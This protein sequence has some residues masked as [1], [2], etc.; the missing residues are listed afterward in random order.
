MAHLTESDRVK[1]ELYLSQGISFQRIGE[2]LNKSRSTILREVL[3]HRQTSNKVPHGRIAN[4][5]IHRRD[6]DRHR[7]CP[8][9]HCHRQCSACSHCN[10]MCPRFQE[11]I[12]PKLSRPRY[13]CNGCTQESQCTL[14]KSFYISNA[15]EQEYR[16]VLVEVRRGINLTEAQCAELSTRIHAGT[17]NGQSIHH[18]MAT[19]KDAFTVCEKT[20][21]GYVNAGIIRTKRGDMPRSCLMKP[22]KRKHME[23]KVDTKCRIGRSYDDFKLYNQEHPD[24]ALVEM[25]SVLGNIG[26][27]VLLTLQLNNCGLMLAFLRNSNNS[28][29]VIDIFNQLEELL[30][31]ELFQRLFPVIL[32]D[33]GSEFSNPSALE[34]SPFT[35]ELRTRIFYCNPYSSWQKGHVENNH[36]NLRKIFE[37]GTSFDSQTQDNINLA[38]SHINSFARRSLNDVPAI[39]LFETLYGEALPA[40]LGIRLIPSDQ[41]LLTPELVTQH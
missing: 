22:R 8:D 7:L 23:H 41:I 9:R 28:Q 3:K 24:S 14:R 33:N 36:L 34:K 10:D 6:C 1:L 16:K 27:K 37:K 12:C 38:L 31:V 39:T 29:S 20:V 21:Y 11:E 4:R 40:R 5:C 19:N 32:T 26:G 18:M 35:G 13:V 2:K 15:A 25:D 17:Q 30:G